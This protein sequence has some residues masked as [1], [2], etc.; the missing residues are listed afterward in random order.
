MSI[1]LREDVTYLL[2]EK[3]FCPTADA[4]RQFDQEMGDRQINPHEILLHLHY[5]AQWG[6]IEA[7][8]DLAAKPDSA[9]SLPLSQVALTQQGQQFYKRLLANSPHLVEGNTSLKPEVSGFLAL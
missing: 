4:H 5:L 1:I 9:N 6:Y 3:L 7:L 2:L 8:S